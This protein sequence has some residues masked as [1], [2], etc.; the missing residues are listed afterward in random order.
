VPN[1]KVYFEF[2]N[3]KSAILPFSLQL[4]YAITPAFGR[5]NIQNVIFRHVFGKGTA[6]DNAMETKNRDTWER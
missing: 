1:C 6:I 3:F 2:Q 4:K 5:T